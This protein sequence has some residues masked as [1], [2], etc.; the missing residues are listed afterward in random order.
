MAQQLPFP[1]INVVPAGYKW[2]NDAAAKAAAK[3]QFLRVGGQSVT[4]RFLS[5]AKRSWTNVK[6]EENQT[7]FH[8]GY[9]ITG[10]PE[11]VRTALQYA[12]VSAADIQQVL[13]TAITRDNYQSTMAQAVNEEM[14]KHL[15]AKGKKPVAEGYEWDQV[16]WFAQNIKTAVIATKTGETKG[17]VQT[18]G[19]VGT[20]D[21]LADKIKKLPAGKV[22][23]VSNMDV[24]TG[25]GLRTQPAPKTDRAGKYGTGRVP[26][27][28]NDINK[29]IRAIQLAYGPEGEA[30]YAGD[31]QIVR[32]ALAK[33]T[34]PQMQLQGQVGAPGIPS[35]TRVAGATIVAQP[36]FVPQVR[37]PAKTVGGANFPFIPALGGILQQK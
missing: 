1:A 24:Q 35:P 33:T 16:L 3:G 34:A 7:I 21:S 23:D 26:I 37:T 19:K 29:Y 12:G 30:T 9:R 25:K 27:I 15:A 10:T 32:D 14:G 28:S 11:A 17:A 20:A 22:I 36:T 13:A 4:R 31:I 6:P 5:G 2:S 18:G 8:T